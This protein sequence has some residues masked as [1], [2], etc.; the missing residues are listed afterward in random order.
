MKSLTSG[1]CLNLLGMMLSEDPQGKEKCA[2]LYLK[3]DCLE[4][5]VTQSEE[6]KFKR[7]GELFEIFF[8]FHYSLFIKTVIFVVRYIR[9]RR[10]EIYHHHNSS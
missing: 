5:S 10:L 4:I 2:I 3:K 1:C 8:F 9:H 7:K 6:P